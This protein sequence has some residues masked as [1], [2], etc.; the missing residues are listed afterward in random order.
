[1]DGTIAGNNQPVQQHRL[2]KIRESI[3]EAAA[4]KAKSLPGRIVHK[5][6][7]SMPPAHIYSIV[8][9]LRVFLST[10]CPGSVVLG[11]GHFGDGNIHINVCLGN[12]KKSTISYKDDYLAESYEVKSNPSKSSL[13]S[14]SATDS[15]NS[16]EIVGGF[17]SN[18]QSEALVNFQIQSTIEI[19]DEY[20][21][22]SPEESGE[23]LC[24][25]FARKRLD[26]IVYKMVRESRGS[27]SAEHGIG[28]L[29][30][31]YLQATKGPV[32]MKLMKLIKH[33]LD[34]EL[35]LNPRKLLL[36]D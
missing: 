12:C 29:K 8:E 1:M 9:T 7:I 25:L 24:S 17:P 10:E 13:N 21:K 22:I 35:I 31:G 33:A 5:Y 36:Q 2:W 15:K 19:C 23:Y 32:E 28:Q 34:P 14:S 18:L 6:D 30:V 3:A 27:I 4:E 11:Y 16:L 26:P 20:S